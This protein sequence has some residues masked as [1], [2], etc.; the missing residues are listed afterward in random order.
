MGG[1]GVDDVE[2]PVFGKRPIFRVQT[3]NCQFTG[4]KGCKW[5]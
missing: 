5:V 2:F 3:A 4:C 1:V